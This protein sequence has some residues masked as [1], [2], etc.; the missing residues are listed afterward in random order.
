M[1]EWSEKEVLNKAAAYCA[2]AERCCSEVRSKLSS[3]G[4][5]DDGK[6]KITE[7]LLRENYIDEN[8]YCR[9]FINDKF[10]F[11]KWGRMKIAQMLRYKGI[12]PEIIREQ[13]LLIDETEYRQTLSELIRSKRKSVKSRDA[14]QLSG[15]LIRFALGR[16]FEMAE[17]RRVLQQDGYAEMD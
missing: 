1:K 7:L 5:P 14:Y 17:I 2:A 4:V 9:S 16:G 12:A 15:K 13:L 8:R 6:S 11:N 10:R 3:W